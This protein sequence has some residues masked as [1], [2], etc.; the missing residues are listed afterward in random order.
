[1]AID[2]GDLAAWH[3][4]VRCERANGSSDDKIMG[5]IFTEVKAQLGQPEIEARLQSAKDQQLI[6]DTE[7]WP[8]LDRVAER[9]RIIINGLGLKETP[10][11]ISLETLEELPL[12]PSNDLLD[13][14]AEYL[15]SRPT[16]IPNSGSN[17]GSTPNLADKL[18]ATCFE[19]SGLIAR[20]LRWFK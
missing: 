20:V 14:Y 8:V 7:L 6:R 12:P 3:Q 11:V 1:M 13:G 16:I 2:S 9:Y 19:D 10:R 4:L 17:T 15:K 5:L 18:A